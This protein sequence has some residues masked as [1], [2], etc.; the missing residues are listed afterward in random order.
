MCGYNSA[1][2]PPVAAISYREDFGTPPPGWCLRA[3]P[4]HLRTDTSGLI[5]FDASSFPLAADEAQALT[6]TL[7]AHLT[8][9]NLR[10]VCRH[11]RRWYLLCDRPQRLAT[12]PLPAVRGTRVSAM[13]Y[14]GEDA[15]PWM[16]R[17]NELQ[18]L[19]HSHPV[20]RDRAERG[21]PAVN[22][23]WLWG[24]GDAQPP[25][26]P[27]CTRLA[28]GNLFARGIARQSGV[29]ITDLPE[30]ASILSDTSVDSENLLVI[31]EACRD[32]AAYE[33]IA[34]WQTA[35]ERLERD[36]FAPLLKALKQRRIDSLKLYA[37]NG[38]CYR[39][40]RRQLLTF[41]KGAGEYRTQAAFRLPSANRV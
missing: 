27:S 18:M 36:W 6:D 5:L 4:V 34:V 40:T 28:G 26:N 29:P 14:G 31:L 9:D 13:P 17:I 35:L 33:D 24:G 25:H 7:T 16:G 1:Q 23:V 32:A 19:M 30:N 10:L 38:R 41:W 37:L 15:A 8:E 3:D 2:M 21:E 22:S 20:N 12:Q 11:P 39:L